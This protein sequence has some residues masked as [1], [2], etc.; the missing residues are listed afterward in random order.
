MCRLLGWASRRPTTL[1]ALLGS[2]P[3]T[4]FTD[5]SRE[6]ADGWGMAW[7]DPSGRLET[8]KGVDAAWESGG[9]AD[10]VGGV[11]TIA[12][13]L[14]L[15]WATPGFPVAPGNTHPFIHENTAFAH[16]GV[17]RPV[18]ALSRLVTSGRTLNGD[19]DSER[20][21][22]LLLDRRRSAGGDAEG[23][24][25][26]ISDIGSTLTTSSLNA[27]VLSPS[28]LQAICCHDPLGQPPP[29]RAAQADGELA[30][31]TAGGRE[32]DFFSLRMRWTP[33][34]VVVASSGWPQDG[35]Q[36]LPNGSLLTVGLDDLDVQV[37]GVGVLPDVARR[38]DT[39]PGRAAG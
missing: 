23:T 24:R 6:H 9:F 19:T 10:G 27:I 16:N 29:P 37:A 20:Y 39:P 25:R 12:G 4:A 8:R 3:L 11:M 28:R 30:P 1:Q 18:D 33:D 35:W 17:I 7:I 5:L 26:V 31:Q 13:C 14:H 21:L 15:R 2:E 32:R 38:R 22:A 34:S 36:R